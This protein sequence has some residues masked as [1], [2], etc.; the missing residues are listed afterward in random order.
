MM[1]LGF[2]KQGDFAQT[3]RSHSKARR[4]HKYVREDKYAKYLKY[5]EKQNAK[6][7]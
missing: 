5:K 2:I 1:D 7:K 3:M 6:L 4:H